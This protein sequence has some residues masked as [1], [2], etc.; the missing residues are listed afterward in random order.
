M[1]RF[2][3]LARLAL[4]LSLGAILLSACAADNPDLPPPPLGRFLLGHNIALVADQVQVG[5]FSRTLENDAIVTSIRSAMNQ[6]FSR[7]DG[8]QYYH[9]SVVVLGYVLAQPGIPVIASPKS[10]LIADVSIYD[11]RDGG[12]PLNAEPKQFTVLEGV[13]QQ[14]VD[15]I[16][17]S[18]FTRSAEE[19]MDSLSQGLT[20]EIVR[21]LQGNRDWF[22]DPALMDPAT[23]SLG[24]PVQPLP[25]MP[26]FGVKSDAAD[27][28][29]G[30]DPAASEATGTSA[31]S[32]A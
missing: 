21:W 16:L 14:P 22:G 25:P 23:T 9:I 15:M 3:R 8:D 28:E 18:G 17:G 24:R 5:P 4:G 29:A 19:Q 10:V 20:G 27:G 7:Y 31:P 26:A 30:A 2:S 13:G 32:G 6:T 12:K 1:S 11:D